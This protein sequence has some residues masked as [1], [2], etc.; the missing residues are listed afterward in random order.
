MSS[1]SSTPEALNGNSLG[2]TLQALFRNNIR[3]YGMLIALV[4]I[5]AFFQIQTDG[6]LLK[7]LNVTNLVLQNSYIVIMAIGMLLVIVAGHIDLSVGSIA[8][9]VGALAAVMIVNYEIN[10][11]VTVIVCLIVG[12]IIGALQGYLVAYFSMPS[13]IV[14]LGGMLAFR[15]LTLTLLQGQS[16]GPF[17]VVFQ[18]LSSGFIPDLFGG[19]A[20]HIT[21]IVLG[22][23]A[24]IAIIVMNVR[25]RNKQQQY[26]LEVPPLVWFLLQNLLTTAGILFMVWLLASHKGLPNVLVILALLVIAYSFLTKNTTI[27]RRIY[28]LGGNV[29]AA[30]LS[31]VKTRWLTFLTFVNL[32]VLSALAGL[33]FTARLNS[34]TPKAG[35]AFELDVIAAVFIGGASATGGIG[36]VIGAVIGALVMGVMNNGMSI[37]GV[38]I[39]WQ[40]T[41]KGLVL[42]IAVFFDVYN[43]NK[44][45]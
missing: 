24:S 42:I 25:A 18:R 2:Q 19:E 6:V 9:F 37:M 38:G 34:A 7:P 39:D 8:A 28:A 5:M 41:I 27:G 10:F 13:F 33:V 1:I 36:T 43:K 15:G 4:I 40:Q 12:G 17:P 29:N 20:L 22:G 26:N 14:T 3:Q 30:L 32:G 31:G 16:I 23:V 11:V 44:A 45:S 21:S 35:T